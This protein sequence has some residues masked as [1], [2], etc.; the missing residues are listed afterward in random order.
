M[1]LRRRRRKRAPG[2]WPERQGRARVL[3]EEA[4]PASGWVVE[5]LLQSEGYDVAVCGGPEILG[6]CFLVEDGR[7]PLAEGA[8]VVLNTLSLSQPD[9]RE[10]VE[11]LSVR[12]P[13]TAVIVGVPLPQAAEHAVLLEGC[14]LMD[15]PPTSGTMKREVREALAK[16]TVLCDWRWWS[17]G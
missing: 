7:R 15:F 11:A 13:G 17:R 2:E 3:V 5:K 9:R 12:L 10:V 4:D 8:D 6:R 1:H 16:R 14:R